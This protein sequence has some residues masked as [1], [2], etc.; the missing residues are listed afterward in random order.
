MTQSVHSID[1]LIA[2]EG[3]TT[4]ALMAERLS[5]AGYRVAQANHLDQGFD[6]LYARKPQMVVVSARMPERGALKLAMAAKARGAKL[7]VLDDLDSPHETTPSIRAFTDARFL[8][9]RL[10]RAQMIEA[11]AALI[12]PAGAEPSAAAAA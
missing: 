4:G 11:T 7:L 5:D 1:I 12:G 3:E 9:R 10:S 6:V 2:H 8:R